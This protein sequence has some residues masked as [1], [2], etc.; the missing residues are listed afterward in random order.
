MNVIYGLANIKKLRRPVIALGVFD[1]VHLGHQYILKTAVKIARRIG[2][3]AVALTFYPHPQE[4]EKI[5]SL[6]HRLNL[7]G[8]TGIDAC[9]VINFN[10]SF[11]KISAVDF[12]SKILTAKIGAFW[13]CVGR[14]FKFG[15]G[16][17]GDV[18]LLSKMAPVYNFNL[19]VLKPVKINN[20][21]V[22]STSIRKL[23][24]DGKL[25]EAQKLLGRPVS[26]MGS[27]IK[28]NSLASGLGFPTANV[29]PHHEVL[30]PDGVYISVILLEGKKF[31]GVC[32]IGTKPTLTQSSLRHV[33]AHIFNFDKNI[34]R[35]NIEI[36]FIKKIRPQK[37]F[38]SLDLL[39]YQIRKD[40]TFT[41]NFFS[42]HGNLHNI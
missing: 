40:I 32:S 27:V 1:G 42:R 38:A 4:E 39:A 18:G 28:G 10:S 34:Y 24:S 21:L 6:R 23:I 30:P 15:K 17:K 25:K 13:V 29:D 5:Y 2:G 22:S 35:K 11:A 8:K 14:D 7:I 31:K 3:T 20:L 37:K 9:I 16:A 41:K 36:L 26:I 19:K 12:I 33:E